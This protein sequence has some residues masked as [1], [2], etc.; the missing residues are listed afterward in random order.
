MAGSS[1]EAPRPPTIAQ[2]KITAVKD[3]Y[4]SAVDP[5]YAEAAKTLS[6]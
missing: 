2:K 1:R 3:S 5:Q 4:A 6:N